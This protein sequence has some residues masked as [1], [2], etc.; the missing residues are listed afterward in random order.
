[1]ANTMQNPTQDQSPV[2]KTTQEGDFEI[3]LDEKKPDGVKEVEKTVEAKEVAPAQEIT[4]QQ[5]LRQ[6]IESID[7]TDH[8]KQQ[9]SAQANAITSL[10]E[11][12]KMKALLK[13]AKE[14]G[15]IF[16]VHM[17]KKMNDPYILDML[18]DTLAKEG[19]YKDF[20][21]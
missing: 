14:K 4:D 18:H 15:V 20:L 12:E 7:L 11:E 9:V 16:A 21:K 2:K 8:L 6:K 13:A 3:S 5:Q 10:S 1:M 17:A 19:H